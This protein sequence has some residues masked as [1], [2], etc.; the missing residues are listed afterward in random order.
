ML[1]NDP[2]LDSDPDPV[3]GRTAVFDLAQGAPN[4]IPVTSADAG[5]TDFEN[6]T[7]SAG[8]V[9]AYSVGDKVGATTNGDGVLVCR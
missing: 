8:S 4:L 6:Q 9:C 2:T 1:G 7:M 3:T 5:S